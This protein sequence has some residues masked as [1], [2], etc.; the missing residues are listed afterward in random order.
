[1]S[2][3]VP[4]IADELVCVVMPAFNAVDYIRAAIISVLS[5]SHGRLELIVVDDGSTDGTLKIVEEFAEH[6]ARLRILNTG[7]RKGVALARSIA[8][9]NASPDTKYIAFLDSDDM[10]VSSKL[11]K[12]L[13]FMQTHR[14]PI[15][16]TAYKKMTASGA[17]GR[18]VISAKAYV[19]Y[20][21]LLKGNCIGCLTAIVEYSFLEKIEVPSTGRRE[22]YRLWLNILRPQGCD[23]Q[24][25][26]DKSNHS[27]QVFAMG[28]N[29]PLAYYR[30]IGGSLS[31][32]KLRAAYS[33]WTVYRNFE[34]LSVFK[35]LYFFINYVIRGFSK[36]ISGW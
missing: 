21:D 5:Q 8:I 34:K 36:Y 25:F 2:G 15:S 7:G 3:V 23:F 17:V 27:S 30:V 31:G 16:F 13:L 32:N 11:E 18:G 22:D 20:H 12:Q 10:W 35:S 28:L 24:K 4:A 33:Q 9:R 19:S 14:C 29:V 6:D 26:G 1:M